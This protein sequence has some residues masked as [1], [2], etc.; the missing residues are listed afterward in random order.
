M[1]NF[2]MRRQPDLPG[3]LFLSILPGHHNSIVWEQV[4]QKYAPLIYGI[5]LNMTGDK[6]I[7]SEIFKDAF[8]GLK[9]KKIL[10][11]NHITLCQTL[12]RH[13]HKLTLKYLQLRGRVQANSSPFHSKFRLLN[14]LYCELISAKEVAQKLNM[15]EQEILLNLRMEFNQLRR[16]AWEEQSQGTLEMNVLN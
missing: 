6:R 15:T 4:Y 14:L 7:A 8:V 10:S 1:N 16:L 3:D 5:I 9:R 13:A 2:R 11:R 12:L